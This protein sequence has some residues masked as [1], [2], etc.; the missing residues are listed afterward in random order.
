[1]DDDDDILLLLQ[2]LT[3]M[4]DPEAQLFAA[5]ALNNIRRECSLHLS[6]LEAM[7]FPAPIMIGST[8]V[9]CQVTVMTALS[10]KVQTGTYPNIEI[11]VLCYISVFLLETA[12]GWVPF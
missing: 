8:P 6:R 4:A 3:S 2:G 11:Y 12:K 10:E 1:M 5:F 9:F 7:T